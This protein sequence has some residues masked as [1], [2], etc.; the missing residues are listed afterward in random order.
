MERGRVESVTE[1]GYTIASWDRD[2]IVT[3]PIRPIDE[4]TYAAGD[5]VYFFLFPDGTGR[6]LA[7]I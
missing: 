6:I 5:A 3:P 4:S 7:G 1:D 2:G